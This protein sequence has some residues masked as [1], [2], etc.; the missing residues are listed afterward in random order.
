MSTEYEKQLGSLYFQSAGRLV[1]LL[2]R[3]SVSNPNVAI[4]EL[5]KNSYDEDATMVRI[6]F[7][8]VKTQR[9]KIIIEDNGN[10][11]ARREIGEKWMRAATQNKEEEPYSKRFRRRRIG[12]KGIAR[13][14]T[15]S[16]CRHILID[17]RVKGEID[18]YR[19]RIDW[20]EYLAPDAMFEKVPNRLTAVP[21]RLNLHGLRIEMSGLRGGWDDDRML[22]LRR[23]IELL[24]PPIGRVEKFNVAL[25]AP[26]FPKFSGKVKA[27]FLN[28]SIYF[29]SSRLE[30]DGTIRYR[31]R[32][33]H[34]QEK[35]WSERRSELSCGPVE[36]CLHFYY[37]EKSKYDDPADFSAVIGSLEHWAGIKLYRDGLRVKPYGDVGNDWI[38]LDKLRVNDPSVYPGNSQIFGYVKISKAN[39]PDLIDT[40]TREGLVKNEAYNDLLT[41]LRNSVK[42]FSDVRREIEGKRKRRALAPRAKRARPVTQRV[43]IVQETLLDFGRQYP[44]IFYNRLEDEIN[45]CYRQGLP[46]AALILSRK[47]IENLFYN[48]LESKYPRQKPTWWDIDKNRPQ[49]FGQMLANLE[50]K[51]IEFVHDQRTLLLKLLELVKPF[52]REANLKAHRLM[53]Y[54]ER[55]E[56]LAGLKIPEIVQVGVKLA[57]KV[58]S[59]R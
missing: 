29:F 36:F 6:T 55:R 20:D 44:E 8:N 48:I 47:L 39:N 10:G 54:V 53:N 16:I 46:N 30:R 23:D 43:E 11:M 26:E 12:E 34:R 27:S 49:H 24:L 9:G 7:E 51:K 40:T 42:G 19:L 4:L 14:G 38:E 41:F 58:R 2:G 37:R 59:T 28:K 21:K 15:D 50:L 52:M 3:E 56:E 22:A 31:M 18:A 5:V 32:S 17:S 1:Q 25:V 35:R 57:D 45:E 33:R 13:F